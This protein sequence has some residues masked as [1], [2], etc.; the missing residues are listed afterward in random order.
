MKR[1]YKSYLPM[2]LV[3]AQVPELGLLLLLIPM[4]DRSLVSN[5]FLEETW[6]G[7]GRACVCGNGKLPKVMGKTAGAFLFGD[8]PGPCF[9]ICTRALPIVKL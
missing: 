7:V 3:A 8:F 5:T 4:P 6:E 9:M 2:L 1:E